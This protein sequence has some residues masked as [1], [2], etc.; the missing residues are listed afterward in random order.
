MKNELLLKRCSTCKIE[1]PL[2]DFG[3]CK[4]EKYGKSYNCKICSRAKANLYNAT[5]RASPQFKERMKNYRKSEKRIEY[6]K[7]YKLKNKGKIKQYAKEYSQTNK[8]KDMVKTYH[9]TIKYKIY[10]S[11]YDKQEEKKQ[12]KRI[13]EYEDRNNISNRYLKEQLKKQGFEKEYIN[14]YPELLETKKE[15]IKIKRLCKI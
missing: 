7:L 3:N 2:D 6:I 8:F 12:N 15:I 11:T 5:Y 9:K 4:K 10:K 13:R 1:K 14:K